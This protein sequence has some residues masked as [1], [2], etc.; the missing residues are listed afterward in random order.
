IIN[1][2]NCPRY[3]S[4]VVK[5][6]KI[7]E[8]PKWLKD[9][10]TS[11]GLRS[12]NNVVDVT[13]FIMQ[14]IGQPLHAFNLDK[15]SG[16]K[17]VV[18]D[19][20]KIEKFTTL[21]SKERK[22][23]PDT[24]MIWD[25]EKPVAVAGVM[26]GENSEVTPDTK[27][28]LIESA[29][30][31]PSAIRK[32]AK[33]LQLSTDASYRYERGCDPNIT[34][35]A[36][37]R[38]A[39]LIAELSGGEILKGAIDVYPEKIQNKEADLRYERV[40]KVLGYEIPKNDVQSIMT[41]LGM[42]IISKDDSKIRVKVPTFRPDIERE[43]DLIEEAARIYGYDKRPPVERIKVLLGEKIDDSKFRDDARNAAVGLG[44]YE[45]I[46]NPLQAKD[47]VAFFWIAYR[48]FKSSKL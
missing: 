33:N 16:K 14:E 30:F 45:M 22:L 38:A 35:Y 9:R 34:A 10:L 41:K 11:V 23:L 8:S 27:N 19:A 1:T 46:N 24:L 28:V 26:G 2:K 40:K 39:Q 21:D 47:S 31:N 37:D 12:I 3:S 32:S 43:I 36:A 29:Y 17:I 20:G 7:Q 4:R 48:N 25:G 44:F 5:N 15:L 18:K 6:V 13:N 42:E